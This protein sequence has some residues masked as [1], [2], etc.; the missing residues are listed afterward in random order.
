MH[1]DFE[2]DYKLKNFP[3]YIQQIYSSE[4]QKRKLKF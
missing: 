3:V 4:I 1:L 2:V